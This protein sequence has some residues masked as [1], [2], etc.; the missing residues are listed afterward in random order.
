MRCTRGS[1]VNLIINCGKYFYRIE[2]RNI[3]ADRGYK[4]NVIF[5]MNRY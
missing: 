2:N 3:F 4:K 1:N 5:W